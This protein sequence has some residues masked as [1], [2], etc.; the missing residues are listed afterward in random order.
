MAGL[1]DFPTE[2]LDV[3]LDELGESLIS[4]APAL[5][6]CC[7]QLYR[8]LVPCLYTRKDVRNRAMAWACRAG[9]LEVVELAA[10]YGAPVSTAISTSGVQDLTL[11]LAIKGGKSD[12]FKLLLQLGARLDDPVMSQQGRQRV[13]SSIM[14]RFC[15]PRY[16]SSNPNLIKMFFESR[17]QNQMRDDGCGPEVYDPLAQLIVAGASTELVRLLLRQGADPEGIRRC[18][19]KDYLCP[20]SAAI[21]VGSPSIFRLLLEHGAVIHGKGMMESP[22]KGSVV[23]ICAAA[24]SLARHHYGMSMMQLC[25]EHGADIN[26]RFPIRVYGPR[27]WTNDWYEASPLSVFLTSIM[28]GEIENDPV[29]GLVYLLDRGA[30]IS[31]PAKNRVTP[32]NMKSD[33]VSHSSLDIV[34]GL[35]NRAAR[36]HVHLLRVVKLLVYYGAARDDTGHLLSKYLWGSYIS[37]TQ[38]RSEQIE[39]A[40]ILIADLMVEETHE[41]LAHYIINACSPI[42]PLA[43]ALNINV[44]QLLIAAGSAGNSATNAKIL[45]ALIPHYTSYADDGTTN[46]A[47]THGHA[48]MKDMSVG[49]TVTSTRKLEDNL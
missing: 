43:D 20:L 28:V 37:S 33:L 42:L 32:F 30:L 41:V 7:K 19:R 15:S 45:V 35:R 2:L 48:A 11:H 40:K 6:R 9:V 29:Q 1:E 31:N 3:L 36:E 4:S 47:V 5:L 46:A 16:A 22:H 18:S 23:P 13:H 21:T 24:I 44:V 38:E 8:R 12:V 17:L 39:L 27:L 25:L 49:L 14:K 26:Q 34:L 10:F